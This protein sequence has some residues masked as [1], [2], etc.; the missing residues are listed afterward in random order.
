M[1]LTLAD[2]ITRTVRGKQI[3][4]APKLSSRLFCPTF[5]FLSELFSHCGLGNRAVPSMSHRSCQTKYIFCHSPWQRRPRTWHFNLH[6]NPCGRQ[7]S[8]F[9][10]AGARR[11]WWRLSGSEWHSWPRI[12]LIPSV[13]FYVCVFEIVSLRHWRHKRIY[14]QKSQQCLGQTTVR[15]AACQSGLHQ[16]EIRP[17]VSTTRPVILQR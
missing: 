7:Y 15:K 1:H 4:F 9:S 17:R 5:P 14:M 8:G 2:N 13:G 10:A 3:N 11:L 12:G 16:T 6:A